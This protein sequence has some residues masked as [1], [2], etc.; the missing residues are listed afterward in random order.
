[1][2]LEVVKLKVAYLAFTQI[3]K[4][5]ILEKYGIWN[6]KQPQGTYQTGCRWVCTY[7]AFTQIT[8]CKILEKY[9]IWNFKQPQ[10][11]YQTGCRWVCTN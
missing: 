2:N 3:T 8:N 7:L 1:M 5:K 9:G 11:T 10:G 6:F 4:C